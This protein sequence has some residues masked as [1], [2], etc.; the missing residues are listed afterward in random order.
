[1]SSESR[2]HPT[3]DALCARFGIDTRYHDV[4]GHEHQVPRATLRSLLAAFGVAWHGEDDD[5]PS[6]VPPGTRSSTR[7]RSLRAR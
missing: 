4:F 2:E 1:M 6:T 7:P 5:T 3:I